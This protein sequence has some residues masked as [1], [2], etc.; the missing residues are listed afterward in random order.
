MADK[1]TS[2]LWR[3]NIISF[4]CFSLLGLTGLI[5]WLLLPKGYEAKASFLV[6]LRHFLVEFHQWT[7]V[8]S[9]LTIAVHILLHLS[10]V[11]SN[12]KRHKILK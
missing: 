3:I 1:K 8:I 5:N 7:A 12:L 2:T 10:Y 11:K 6:S 9:M 4:I